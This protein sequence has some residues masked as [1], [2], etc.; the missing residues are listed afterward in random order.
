VCLQG[1]LH[2]IIPA[3]AD[4]RLTEWL[5]AAHAPALTLSPARQLSV[6]ASPVHSCFFS[7]QH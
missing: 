3:K 5:Y 6:G 4:G 1:A 7:F 2:F